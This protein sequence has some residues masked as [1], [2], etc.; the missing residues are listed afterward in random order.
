[1]QGEKIGC[2]ANWPSSSSPRWLRSWKR[3]RT[4]SPRRC[5]LLPRTAPGCGWSRPGGYASGCASYHRFGVSIGHI[6]E[7]ISQARA[8]ADEASAEPRPTSAL[9]RAPPRPGSQT[10]DGKSYDPHFDLNWRIRRVAAPGPRTREAVLQFARR[11]AMDAH[12][13]S[14]LTPSLGRLK[15][16]TGSW[17]RTSSPGPAGPGPGYRRGAA[18]PPGGT[19]SAAGRAGPGVPGFLRPAGPGPRAVWRMVAAIGAEGREP[20]RGAA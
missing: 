16:G 20:G 1:V 19:P 7:A 8:G 5:P 18:W 10:P 14:R 13:G 11:S 17:P 12:A 6:G 15:A 2:S 9:R 4:R 3:W